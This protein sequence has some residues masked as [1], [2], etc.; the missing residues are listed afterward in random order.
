V[1]EFCGIVD[2][3]LTTYNT[4]TYTCMLFSQPKSWAGCPLEIFNLGVLRS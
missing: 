1:T 4:D 3:L 2:E